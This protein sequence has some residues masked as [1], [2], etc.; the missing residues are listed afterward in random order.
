MADKIVAFAIAFFTMVKKNTRLQLN[1]I[2][3]NKT[4]QEWISPFKI[5]YRFQ[6]E[7]LTVILPASSIN[8]L[9]WSKNQPVYCLLEVLP[10]S[11][12]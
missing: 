9:C 2:P 3:S 5:I 6:E 11:A 1:I 4:L 8:F 7:H 12:L 10:L